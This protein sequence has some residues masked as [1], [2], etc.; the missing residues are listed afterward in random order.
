[1]DCHFNVKCQEIAPMTLLESW[2]IDQTAANVREC[3]DQGIY[4]NEERFLPRNLAASYPIAAVRRREELPKKSKST[5]LRRYV[6]QY[7]GMPIVKFPIS[8]QT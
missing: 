1:M 6:Y 8:E 4:R 7:I 3:H 2:A 5:V